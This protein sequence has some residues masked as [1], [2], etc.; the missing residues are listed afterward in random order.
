MFLIQILSLSFRGCADLEFGISYS[1]Q[2]FWNFG[3]DEN[4]LIVALNKL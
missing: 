2:S 4:A 3:F 1:V